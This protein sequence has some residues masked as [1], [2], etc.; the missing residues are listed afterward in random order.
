[1]EERIWKII[2][3]WN[4]W[5]RKPDLGIPRDVTEKAKE[6]IHGPD[7]VYF[8]GP[9]RSGKTTVCL[10]IL[11]FLADK[12]G[13]HSC[14]Y[15]N[16][17]EPSFSGLLSTSFLDD[18][19]AEFTKTFNKKPKYIFLD[20]IQNVPNWEKW[21]RVNVDKKTFKIFVTGSSAKL[22]SSEF[23][24]TLG[25]RGLGFLVLPFSFKEFKKVHPKAAL[26]DYL[27]IG[28][29]P[30]VVLEKNPEKR[31]RMLEEYF[32]S[33]ITRDIS[34]RYEVRDV[35]T[36]RTLAVY[37]ITNSGKLFSYN[38]LRAMTGLSFDAIKMY[39]S[40]LEDA[41][42]A[43]HVPAFS[44]SLKKAMEKPRRYYAYDTGLQAAISKSFSL[45]FGRRTENAVAIELLRSGKEIQYYSNDFEIDFIV[46]EGLELTAINVCATQEAPARET[47]S[48][49]QFSKE[50]KTKKTFLLSGEKQITQWFT[51]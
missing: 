51:L 32:D 44:Y 16:F 40:Y 2:E 10:Q 33:A 35:P 8:Y 47:S 26:K 31:L 46:K 14:L 13:K 45:D 34:T 30:A 43:F 48:L 20:E 9:R 21:V 24:T 5:T 4:Y 39:L 17:E 37:V 18:I 42:I 27:E 29:Y 11:S 25:G 23:S 36:L 19:M 50:H 38:K 1:M 3:S 28:G 12:H 15:V 49:E 7:A 6:L 22:L 41:F